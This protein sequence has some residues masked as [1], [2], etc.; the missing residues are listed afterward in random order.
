MKTCMFSCFNVNFKHESTIFPCK[1]TICCPLL[2]SILHHN[3]TGSIPHD[4]STPVWERSRKGTVHKR[5]TVCACI[6]VYV[7]SDLCYVTA[8]ATR[9]YPVLRLGLAPEEVGSVYVNKCMM[10][11]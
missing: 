4:W 6:H 3:G 7:C 11:V 10:H 2:L 1:F 5:C 9:W 8:L